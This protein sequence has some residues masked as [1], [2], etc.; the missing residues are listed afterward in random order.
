MRLLTFWRK[1][2]V[3][4]A[5]VDVKDPT[6]HEVVYYQARCTGCGSV[7]DDYGD[8]SAWAQPDVVV[9]MAVEGC[10]W[11]HNPK[12]DDELLCPGCQTCIL[13]GEPGRDVE[14][15][16]VLLCPEHEDIEAVWSS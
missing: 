1:Q 15:D 5:P 6:I 13:C 12:D 10:G 7:C 16:G 2:K 11:W 4:P 14:D 9:E 3:E 8:Y